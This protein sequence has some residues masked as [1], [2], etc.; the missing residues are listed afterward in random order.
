MAK[1]NP[2]L[3]GSVSGKIG[4]VVG[5]SW[6]GVCYLKSLAAK[7][8]NPKTA[9]QVA[10]RDLMKLT[11]QGLRPFLVAIRAGYKAVKGLS[12]WSIAISRNRSVIVDAA[13]GGS[14][15]TFDVTRVELT[16]GV[17]SFDVDVVK[18]REGGYD[19]SWTPVDGESKLDGGEVYVVVYNAKT[20]RAETFRSE[21][22][23]GAMTVSAAGLMT[24]SG[25]EIHVYAFAASAK[26]SSAT[27]H[28]SFD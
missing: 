19:A 3:F 7:V 15:W 24:G 27:R 25:D 21:M 26:G 20:K 5:S 2:G 16:N 23:A 4:N 13:A 12:S 14:N 8:K 9:A 6:N 18:N 28:Y 10:V 17:E 1:Y 11:T 22:S